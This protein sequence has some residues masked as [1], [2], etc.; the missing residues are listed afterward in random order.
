MALT[1]PEADSLL[2]MPKEFV[3]AGLL[4]FSQNEPMNCD[5]LLQ[6]LDR[7]E[8]FL[9]TVERGQRK[10][11][12]LKYQTRARKVITLARLDINGPAHRNPP[13]SPQSSERKACRAP[14]AFISRELRR[15]NRV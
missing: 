15:S 10:R 13:E 11:I 12:R 5:R 1:Q 3:D 14:Y 6:S 4:E 2:Q 9:L 8:Q 7:R